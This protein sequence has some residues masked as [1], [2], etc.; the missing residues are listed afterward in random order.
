[1]TG[2]QWR[3]MGFGVLVHAVRFGLIMG[4]LWLAPLVG[5]TG[6]YMG[7]FANA[8]CSIYAAVLIT[9]Y[10]LWKAVGIRRLWRGRT[11]AL[12]LLVPWRNRWLGSCPTG[13]H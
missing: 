12:F 3:G 2:E 9:H 11:A 4:A 7:L 6:W 1:M 10:R 13:L 8:L 5:I